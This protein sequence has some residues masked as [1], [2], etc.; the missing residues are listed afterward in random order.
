MSAGC[1]ALSPSGTVC[2][3]LAGHAMVGV[4]DHRDAACFSWPLWSRTAW[5]LRLAYAMASSKLSQSD[6]ARALGWHRQ[7]VHWM[8]LGNRALDVELCARLAAILGC[9]RE[10][11]AGWSELHG[12]KEVDRV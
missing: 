11:L 8:M 6:L 2:E 7:R 10:W 9:S 4:P 3:L 12:M 1:F 5:H